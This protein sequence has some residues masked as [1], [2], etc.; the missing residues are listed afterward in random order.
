MNQR[1]EQRHILSDGGADDKH[2][3][4]NPGSGRLARPRF[5]CSWII[6]LTSCVFVGGTPVA[7]AFR[8]VL[9]QLFFEVRPSTE[10][11]PLGTAML[12]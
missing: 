12:G 6:M 3:I 10:S 2:T 7:L 11:G 8:S 1:A 9:N 5:K 4:F